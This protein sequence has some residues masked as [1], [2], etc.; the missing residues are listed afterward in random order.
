MARDGNTYAKKAR[1][2][3]KR[4][5]AQAKRER[6]EKRKELPEP[7]ISSPSDPPTNEA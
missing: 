7:G 5:K 4:Q 6:R 3:Q 2:T 1:E